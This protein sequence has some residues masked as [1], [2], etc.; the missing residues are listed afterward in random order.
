MFSIGTIIYFARV[1]LSMFGNYYNANVLTFHRNI[2]L[3]NNASK[4]YNH[5]MNSDKVLLKKR[6]QYLYKTESVIMIIEVA[7][8]C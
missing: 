4:D 5:L 8:H 2:T 6:L 1:F 7:F 3:L